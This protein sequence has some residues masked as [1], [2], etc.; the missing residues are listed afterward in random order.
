M[1][2]INKCKGR[3]CKMKRKLIFVLGILLFF[4]LVN[5]SSQSN[6][7][8]VGKWVSDQFDEG[9][10]IE[11][12]KDGSFIYFEY[13]PSQY[14]WKATES[15]LLTLKCVEGDDEIEGIWGF[16][17]TGSTLTIDFGREVVTLKRK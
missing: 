8:L 5:C 6:N 17:I 9:N 13:G 12:F 1:F 3:F 11:F 4:A 16:K 10:Y 14:T 7:T 15:G 2:L